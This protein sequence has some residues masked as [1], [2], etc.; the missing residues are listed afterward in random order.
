MRSRL[1]LIF[2]YWISLFLFPNAVTSLAD[3]DP[4]ASQIPPMIG[5]TLTLPGIVP[6]AP[7][8]FVA[9]G[10]TRFTDPSNVTDTNPKVRQFLVKQIAAEKPLAIFIT[11]DT[12]FTGSD[13]ADWKVFQQETKAWRDEKLHVF[14]TTGNHEIK[15]GYNAGVANYLANFPQLKGYRYYSA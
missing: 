14:P 15:D 12:P 1:R 9:Y 11:G 10:D 3:S 5:P 7:M 2:C 4:P 6:G 13:P 8:K